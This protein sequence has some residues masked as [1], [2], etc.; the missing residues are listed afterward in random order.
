MVK[1]IER[2]ENVMCRA[3]KLVPHLNDIMYLR[4]LNYQIWHTGELM[5]TKLK[6]VSVTR[7]ALKE[8]LK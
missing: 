3:T 5:L 7:N 6:A 4:R 8:F 2:V 1:D